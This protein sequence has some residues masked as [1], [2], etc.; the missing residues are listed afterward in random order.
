[1]QIRFD[2]LF[3]LHALSNGHQEG[4]LNMMGTGLRWTPGATQPTLLRYNGLFPGTSK[5]PRRIES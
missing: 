5:L 2:S 4:K 1:M 3:A